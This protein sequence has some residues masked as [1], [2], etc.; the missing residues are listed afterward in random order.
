MSA[1]LY[2]FNININLHISSTLGFYFQKIFRNSCELKADERKKKSVA[3]I[4]ISTRQKYR[5]WQLSRD[6][7]K[8]NAFA[9]TI[10]NTSASFAREHFHVFSK[11]I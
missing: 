10:S 11:S 5:K 3:A 9:E 8:R 4:R 2:N 1:H 6:K 7:L